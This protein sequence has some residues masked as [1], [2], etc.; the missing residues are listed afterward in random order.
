[1]PFGGAKESGVGRQY[2]VLGL[3]GYME[4][5]VVSVLKQS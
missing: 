3:K 1:V 2:S 5:R 4:P